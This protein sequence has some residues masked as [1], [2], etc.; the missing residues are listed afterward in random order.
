M[1]HSLRI[2]HKLDKAGAHLGQ[3]LEAIWP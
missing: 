2:C 3:L 1:K